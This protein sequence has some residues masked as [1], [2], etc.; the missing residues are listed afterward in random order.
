MITEQQKREAQRLYEEGNVCRKSQKWAE[1]Q[2]LY[3]QA[4]ALDPTSPAVAAREM[5]HQ[6]MEYR[7]KEYYN[8]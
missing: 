6:I 7:C 8:P 1:A 2:N 4:A 3:E 5:L